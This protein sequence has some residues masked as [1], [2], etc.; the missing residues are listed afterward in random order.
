M[1][2]RSLNMWLANIAL[3]V[4]VSIFSS[5]FCPLQLSAQQGGPT[6]AS[7]LRALAFRHV[8]VIDV[9]DGRHLLDQTVVVSGNRVQ[10]VG[11]AGTVS[12]PSGAQVIDAQGKYMIPGLWDMELVLDGAPDPLMWQLIANGITGYRNLGQIGGGTAGRTTIDSM[13]TWRREIASGSRIGPRILI[14]GPPIDACQACDGSV[15]AA[16]PAQARFLVDSLKTAGADHIFVYSNGPMRRDVAF[17][18]LAEGRR[19]HIPVVG[20]LPDSLTLVEASDSGMHAVDHAHGTDGICFPRGT[21]P[22][23]RPPSALLVPDSPT[24]EQ[25]TQLATRLR[26]NDTWVAMGPWYTLDFP[27]RLTEQ[28]RLRRKQYTPQQFREPTD[29]LQQLIVRE[30][31]LP[32]DVFTIADRAGLPILLA[33]DMGAMAFLPVGFQLHD[34]LA[35]VVE[36]GLKPLTALQAV[37][38]N[39]AKYLGATDSLGTVEAG[40]LADLVLLD[41]DPLADIYNTQRIRAVVAN[42]RYFDRATLDSLLVRA[43]AAE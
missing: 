23:N 27:S 21:L 38:L 14:G 40:K 11:P 2:T 37:T 8:T 4:I 33:S 41:A 30:H 26:R 19:L 39:P 32:Y 12:L 6:S 43:G 34:D 25:C 20:H 29:F 1:L 24:V 5:I 36:H 7:T 16:T 22:G 10:V 42:G 18:L 31:N 15:D 13:L 9:Q 28:E 3:G 35:M 17:A